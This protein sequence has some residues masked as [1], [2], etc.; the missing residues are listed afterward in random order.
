[1]KKTIRDKLIS[2]PM[3]R[4]IRAAPKNIQTIEFK[5]KKIHQ[6]PNF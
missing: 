2:A 4:R 1:M 5:F 3:R 6:L